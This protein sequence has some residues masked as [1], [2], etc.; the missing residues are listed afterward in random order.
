LSMQSVLRLLV[1]ALAVMLTVLASLGPIVAFFFASTTSYAFMLLLNVVIFAAS[2]LLGLRYMLMTLHRLS[3]AALEASTS[4]EREI[5]EALGTLT[6]S[7]T[8][9]LQALKS[10]PI[11]RDVRR[12]FYAWIVVFGFVGT[13]MAWVLRPFLSRSS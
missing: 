8:G 4:A 10:R 13:Q 2:G 1:I 3:S 12:V 5:N 7:P 9:A 6:D 11:G